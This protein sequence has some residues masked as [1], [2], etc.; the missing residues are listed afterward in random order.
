M[1]A[2]LYH[3]PEF[4]TK[5]AGLVI[6]GVA[7]LADI[8]QRVIDDARIPYIRSTKTSAEVYT[9]IQ[10]DVAKIRA[11]DREKIA[12]VQNLA[13]TELDFDTIDALF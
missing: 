11:D 12:L 4:K 3:L 5:I 2:T 10:E 8:V 9:T 1:L 13:E 7:P 6:T